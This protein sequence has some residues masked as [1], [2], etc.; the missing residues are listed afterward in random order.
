MSRDCVYS[1]SS[2]FSLN[3]EAVDNSE[4]NMYNVLEHFVNAK[5]KY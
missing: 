5:C 2:K 3:N 1:F 4:V